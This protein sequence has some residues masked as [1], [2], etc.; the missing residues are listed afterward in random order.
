MEPGLPDWDISLA[1]L[2]EIPS[3]SR[4]FLQPSKPLT[5]VS[6]FQLKGV[7]FLEDLTV[8]LAMVSAA[9]N[10]AL[11]SLTKEIPRLCL[12]CWCN[13][14]HL[15]FLFLTDL[16]RN[17][18]YQSE[19]GESIWKHLQHC[20]TAPVAMLFGSGFIATYRRTWWRSLDAKRSA[21]GYPEC[22]IMLWCSFQSEGSLEFR[23]SQSAWTFNLCGKYSAIIM[24][25]WDSR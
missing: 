6:C 13:Y 25:P 19:K 2:L 21:V 11:T 22:L 12:P 24:I 16:F 14:Y 15:L 20:C 17:L 10:I 8:D 18:T 7:C 1:A 4:S 3:I 23:E 5:L 9:V